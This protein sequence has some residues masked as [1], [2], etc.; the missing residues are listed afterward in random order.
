MGKISALVQSPV[1]LE[2]SVL[3]RDMLLQHL[4]EMY[5]EVL[6][7]NESKSM[8]ERQ[9]PKIVPKATGFESRLGT[10]TRLPNENLIMQERTETKEIKTVN[11]EDAV[12]V[13]DTQ[14]QTDVK[15][16]TINERTSQS[17][18]LN[19]KLKQGS[20]KEVH[21]VLSSKPLRE[22]IDFN[23]R[24]ALVNELFKGN[25][26]AFTNAIN[27]IDSFREYEE[28][29]KFV[30]HE[31]LTHYQWDN[32]GQTTRLFLKLVKQRFGEE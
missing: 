28:A 17:S 1:F 21:R 2:G 9:D 32:T 27:Q 22:L 13:A 24:I 20:A 10:I 23:K 19:Q 18:S 7:M 30:V 29:E 31:L 3:E 5:D 15:T 26:E 16:P 4:R 14:I 8:P 25:S 12:S 6:S 11:K